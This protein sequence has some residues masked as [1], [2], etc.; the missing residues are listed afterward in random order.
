MG[1]WLHAPHVSHVTAH[2]PIVNSTAFNIQLVFGKSFEQIITKIMLF[3]LKRV[4]ILPL[5]PHD[6]QQ[7]CLSFPWVGFSTAV[8]LVCLCPVLPVPVDST[9]LHTQ[10]SSLS[11]AV[12]VM[13][14]RSLLFLSIFSLLHCL[15]LFLT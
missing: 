7:E 11:C 15:L 14:D 2:L 6:K 10:H 5:D 9:C 1:L 13:L 3:C 12:P 4:G 8:D